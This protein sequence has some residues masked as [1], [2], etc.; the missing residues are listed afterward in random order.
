MSNDR[1]LRIMF[2][3]TSRYTACTN[4]VSTCRDSRIQGTELDDVCHVNVCLSPERRKL[5]PSEA[6]AS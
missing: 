3:T 2:T 4:D 1:V 6:A 5:L